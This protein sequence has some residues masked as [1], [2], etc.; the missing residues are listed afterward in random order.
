VAHSKPNLRSM[1]LR[2]RVGIPLSVCVCPALE[3]LRTRIMGKPIIDE[4]VPS[5]IL[6]STVLKFA[7]PSNIPYS[8]L[9]TLPNHHTKSC[10]IFTV[11]NPSFHTSRKRCVQEMGRTAMVPNWTKMGLKLHYSPKQI[12][13][14]CLPRFKL[15]DIFILHRFY[16]TNI[17]MQAGTQL[18]R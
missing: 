2:S 18:L 14:H 12:N 1:F 11:K 3:N 13:R 8:I 9:I 16:F 6:P 7:F 15:Y 5:E 17:F 10:P 4:S